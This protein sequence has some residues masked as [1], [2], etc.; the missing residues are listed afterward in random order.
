MF[1]WKIK[2]NIVLRTLIRNFFW[3]S[4]YRWVDIYSLVTTLA[5]IVLK[6]A[7]GILLLLGYFLIFDGRWPEMTS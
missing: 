6:V 1:L 3:F 7:F 5:D 4:W 2:P